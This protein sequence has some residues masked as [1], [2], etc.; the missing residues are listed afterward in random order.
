MK[1]QTFMEGAFVSTIG[2]VLCK[3]IGMLYV[4][5]FRA[6]IGVKGA[7]LYSYA[8]TIYSVFVSLSS[9][10]VPGAMAKTISEYNALGY[11]NTQERAYKIG[12]RIIVA[13][14]VISFLILFV[15]APQIAY[16]IIGDIKGGNTIGDITY[17][18]RIISTALLIIPFLSTS[19]GYIQGHKMMIIPA[20]ANVMEQLARVIVIIGG[21]YLT[22]NIFH[23]SITTAVGVATFGATIG[24]LV[25]YIY[26]LDKIK[27]NR[28]SLMRDIPKTREESKYTNKVILSRFVKFS[29]PFILIELVRS[30]YNT[31]DTFTIVK[32]LVKLGYDVNLAENVLSIIT[33]WGS[34]LNMIV[35]SISFG[36]TISIIPNIASSAILKQ[37]DDVSHKINQALKMILFTSLPLSLGIC[38]LSSSTWTLFYGYDKLSVTIFGFLILQTIFHSFY[39]ILI[40]TANT[41]SKPKLALG[42]LFFGFLLKLLLNTPMMGLLQFIGI[43]AYY[44]PIVTTMLVHII[45]VIYLLIMLK[46]TYKINYKESVI[47]MIKIILISL[48]MMIVLSIMRLLIGPF[49]TTRFSSFLEIIIYGSVGGFIY[50]Y[51]SYKYKLFES[52]FGKEMLD[53]FRRKFKKR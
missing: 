15:F 28:K 22:L 39:C 40:D 42:T 7:I 32:G 26:I 1:K 34:K 11:Y 47:P 10:G 8:Y 35:L 19:K 33:T 37:Y 3:V 4:I 31:V 44:G 16:L 41:L 51:L 43:D 30:L 13:I 50:L 52:V 46:K 27:K 9:A 49:N 20:V 21:S 25:A 45:S 24:A 6:I 12:K 38:F 23:L 14:G 36:L 48:I 29:L 2:F 18:I 5:P 53:K 17:V